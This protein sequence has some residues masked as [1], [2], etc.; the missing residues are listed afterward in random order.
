MGIFPGAKVTRGQDWIWGDQDGEQ[1][2]FPLDD[3][4]WIDTSEMT[5]CIGQNEI[6]W[7]ITDE[8]ITDELLYWLVNLI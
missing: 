5:W 3:H 2:A 1:A 7:L 8:L 6:G 4:R